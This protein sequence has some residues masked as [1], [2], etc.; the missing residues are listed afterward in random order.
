MFSMVNYTVIVGE[1][2][3]ENKTRA[4]SLVFALQ[5]FLIFSSQWRA[6]ALNQTYPS[7]LAGFSFPRLLQLVLSRG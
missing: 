2:K 6:T 7:N 4:T 3:A 1:G 5:P